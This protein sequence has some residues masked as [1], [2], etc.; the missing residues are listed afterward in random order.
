MLGV[1]SQVAQSSTV[2]VR[3]DLRRAEVLAEAGRTSLLQRHG[4]VARPLR[5]RYSAH[6]ANIAHSQS[7]HQDPSGVRRTSSNS[8]SSVG[9][10]ARSSSTEAAR[11]RGQMSESS[12]RC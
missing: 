12:R 6:W 7:T 9:T 5:P 1:N 2:F 3:K 10:T 8:R 4:L 11:R